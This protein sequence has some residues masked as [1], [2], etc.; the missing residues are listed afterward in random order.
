MSKSSLAV[1]WA[2]FSSRRRRCLRLPA[3]NGTR[4]EKNETK[5][6]NASKPALVGAAADRRAKRREGRRS[7]LDLRGLALG[8]RCVLRRFL[9][10][11]RRARRARRC[12]ERALQESIRGMNSR[13]SRSS[14]NSRSSR[15][16]TSTSSSRSSRSTRSSS[17]AQKANKRAAAKVKTTH[18]RLLETVPVHA[19]QRVAARG[20]TQ[21]R[22]AERVVAELRG[23]VV[24]AD[25][26]EQ[27]VVVRVQVDEAAHHLVHSRISIW[28][29]FRVHTDHL[30][31]IRKHADG[32]AGLREERRTFLLTNMRAMLYIARAYL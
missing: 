32:A 4:E 22:R 25:R 19:P 21:H 11:R 15:S 5:K 23:R 20:D 10:Q 1:G 9:R 27:A 24:A 29:R 8:R 30:N 31:T 2:I 13:Y 28:D 17:R 26:R 7:H 18:L 3:G 16:S 14:R 12:V 6:Q